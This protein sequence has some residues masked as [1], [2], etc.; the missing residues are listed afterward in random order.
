MIGSLTGIVDSKSHNS[1]IIKVGGVG[2]IIFVTTATIAE[3]HEG[4]ELSVWTHLAVRENALDLY[5]FLEHSDLVFFQLL[6]EVSG[7]G[8][9]TALAVL[10]MAGSAT[11]ERAILSGDAGYLTKVSGIGAKSAQKIVLELKD[12]LA[13]IGRVADA[14]NIRE[15]SDAIDAL[16]ALGY[17]LRDAREALGA[18]DSQHITTNAKIREA[19]RLLGQK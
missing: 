3:M 10:S 5:G 14:T 12:K 13:K 17:P 2:Y 11:L 18:I 9:K 19:L 15:E 16:L 8:P 6:L 7:I 4:T 1:L